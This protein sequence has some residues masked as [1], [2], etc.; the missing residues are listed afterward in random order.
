MF[1]SVSRRILGSTLPL[2]TSFWFLQNIKE[3]HLLSCKYAA[4]D[5]GVSRRC[6]GGTAPCEKMNILNKK[7]TMIWLQQIL[8][9]K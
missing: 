5:R 6:G 3:M 1:D 7:N 9:K 2:A 8:N 4:P